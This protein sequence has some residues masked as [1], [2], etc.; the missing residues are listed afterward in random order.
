MP[1][2]PSLDLLN[3]VNNSRYVEWICDAIP[4]ET[5]SRKK[6]DWLQINY[7]HETRPGEDVVGIGQPGGK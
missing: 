2:T 3:H 6:L 1:V 5:F 4:L 7:D